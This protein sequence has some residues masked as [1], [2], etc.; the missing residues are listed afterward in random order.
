MDLSSTIQDGED[1]GLKIT[2]TDNLSAQWTAV[3]DLDIR[4]TRINV[5]DISGS[6]DIIEP[7]IL[8]EINIDLINMG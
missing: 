6:Y 7:G 1:C 4:G 2:I 5:M 3:L 8:N